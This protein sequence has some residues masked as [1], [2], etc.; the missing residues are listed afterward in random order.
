MS[1]TINIAKN[2]GYNAFDVHKIQWRHYFRIETNDW[3]LVPKIKEEL[4]S[5]YNFP[6]YKINVSST[7]FIRNDLDEEEIEDLRKDRKDYG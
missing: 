1:W 3:W 7:T 2:S 6:D 4:S 5:V